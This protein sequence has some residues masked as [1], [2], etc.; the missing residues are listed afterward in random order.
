MQGTQLSRVVIEKRAIGQPI[1]FH[2][3]KSQLTS[4]RHFELLYACES[5]A[6]TSP[7]GQ[8]SFTSTLIRAL[9]DLVK[10]RASGAFTT[11]D[12]LSKIK[13]DPNLRP[14]QRPGLVDKCTLSSGGQ[15][16]L[17]PL[18]MKATAAQDFSQEM[19]PQTRRS[20]YIFN[21]AIEFAEKPFF[22]KFK[23]FA[24]N[25]FKALKSSPVDILS[26]RCG[27]V[28][29]V[30]QTSKISAL[31]EAVNALD[32]VETPRNDRTGSEN[33]SSDSSYHS[34]KGSPLQT[35]TDAP[36]PPSMSPL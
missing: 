25:V 35:P 32:L 33:D 1:H 15:L 30:D 19:V 23:I 8:R 13:L 6:V 4:S 7:P 31:V 11:L 14:D 24:D 22:E 27:G 34:R 9:N 10:Q 28:E 18:P 16:V 5:N 2:S 17:Q 36:A 29:Q 20:P 3:V 12:L 21:F 26:S